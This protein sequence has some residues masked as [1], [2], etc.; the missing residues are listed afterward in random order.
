MAAQRPVSVNLVP[1]F[2]EWLPGGAAPDQ[3]VAAAI[4]RGVNG[5]DH[6]G[7]GVTLRRLVAGM[8]EMVQRAG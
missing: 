7:G 6:T 8:P 1:D 4:R 5:E 2:P 3:L